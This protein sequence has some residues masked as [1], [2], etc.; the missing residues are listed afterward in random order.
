MPTQESIDIMRKAMNLWSAAADNPTEKQY[1]DTVSLI[2][3]AIKKAGEP[4]PL[5]HSVLAR[6]HFDVENYE[7]AWEAA[8]ATLALDEY[9]YHAQLIKVYLMYHLTVQAVEEAHEKR[10][11][12]WGAI[13]EIFR[14]KGIGD[15]F[16]AGEK[17]GAALTSGMGVGKM[18]RGLTEGVEKLVVIFQSMWQDGSDASEVVK[19]GNRLI[20][21]ADGMSETPGMLDRD[22]NLYQVVA[23]LQPDNLNY[24]TEEERENVDTL[25]LIAEGRM[26]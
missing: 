7:A 20:K 10:S 5:A 17:L 4:V 16:R 23:D 12:G 21:L 19:F 3:L 26:S 1:R 25:R 22:I 13:G 2:Q 18:K 9:D 14:S 15:S 6:I 11:G 8:E 24:E